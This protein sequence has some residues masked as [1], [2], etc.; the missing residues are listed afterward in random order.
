MDKRIVLLLVAGIGL[1]AL[2][3]GLVVAKKK[4]DTTN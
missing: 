3:Y 1:S 2:W 4:N